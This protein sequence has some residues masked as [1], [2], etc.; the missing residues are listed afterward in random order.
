[1]SMGY[2]IE[3]ATKLEGYG[4]QKYELL[5]TNNPFKITAHNH[6]TKTLTKLTNSA[7][8]VVLLGFLF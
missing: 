4:G 5:Q 2:A 7:L 3:H 6:D 8:S 1:M